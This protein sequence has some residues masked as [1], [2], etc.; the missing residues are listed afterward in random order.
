MHIIFTLLDKLKLRRLK[1]V[2]L[3]QV[4]VIAIL[5]NG[6]FVFK[7]D[8]Y[9]EIRYEKS[10]YQD[11]NS[12]IY[13]LINTRKKLIF[14]IPPFGLITRY[15]FPYKI[16][17]DY[18]VNNFKISKFKEGIVEIKINDDK[19]YILKDS[20]L[21]LSYSQSKTQGRICDSIDK[22]YY[23]ITDSISKIQALTTLENFSDS[24][25]LLIGLKRKSKEIKKIYSQN[26]EMCYDSMM[27]VYRNSPCNGE[28]IF[29]DK[30]VISIKDIDIKKNSLLGQ[31]L[32]KSGKKD[33]IL[34]NIQ[35]K[36]NV[37]GKD[38][39]IYI[40]NIQMIERIVYGFI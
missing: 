35:F 36:L 4:I 1:I 23:E 25:K 22:K 20:A 31:A 18:K 33:K 24:K 21:H 27:N 32:H 2:F 5:V 38:T 15:G 12:D 29:I 17:I 19:Y 8:R 13:V 40:N 6:C 7:F 37:E 26:C 9:W 3:L 34:L 16:S 39:V 28:S 30:G 10:K 11:A 14:V